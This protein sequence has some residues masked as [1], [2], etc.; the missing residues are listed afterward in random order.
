MHQS[1]Y[2]KMKTFSEFLRK[3]KEGQSLTIVDYGSQDFN[4]SYRPLFGSPSWKYIGI[5]MAK[6]KN[7]DIVLGDPYDWREIADRSV[8]I[9][10][11]GQAFEHTEYLWI[12]FLEIERV[13]R[14]GGFAC[15]ITPSSGPE[16]R[17]PLDCWRI[18]PD[19][20]RALAAF[21]RLEVVD[22]FTEWNPSGYTD[23]SAQWKDTVLIARKPPG[24]LEYD[25]GPL[26]DVLKRHLEGV[27]RRI[28]EKAVQPPGKC[29]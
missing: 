22:A 17:F 11:S 25:L 18:Y 24:A 15:V 2:A 16:H 20:L 10:I 4:G 21:A 12:S 8:D 19:G 1:S 6:G 29:A 13:L 14:P 26:R 3:S 5:D 27:G 28:K 23:G 7:V 9:F